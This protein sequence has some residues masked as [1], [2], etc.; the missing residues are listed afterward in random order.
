MNLL[1]DKLLPIKVNLIY[2]IINQF[3]MIFINPRRGY[4]LS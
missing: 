3:V 2:N 1:N 4:L